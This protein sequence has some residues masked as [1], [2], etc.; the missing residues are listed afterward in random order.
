MKACVETLMAIR[1][2]WQLESHGVRLPDGR[3]APAASATYLAQ[4][5]PDKHSLQWLEPTFATEVEAAE[6]GLNAVRAWLDARLDS[7]E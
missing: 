3:F 6:W 4:P 1:D 5:R 2:K 7:G